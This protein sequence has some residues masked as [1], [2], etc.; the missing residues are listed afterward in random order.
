MCAKVLTGNKLCAK[1]YVTFRVRGKIMKS[2]I[3]EI[4]YGRVACDKLEP[5]VEYFKRFDAFYKEY[6]KFK[7]A[8]PEKLKPQFEKVLDLH[9]ETEAESGLDNFKYGFELGL[10]IGMEIALK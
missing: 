9:N 10:S 2:A 6:E 8:L 5:S 7:A 4:Y 1:I 3:K